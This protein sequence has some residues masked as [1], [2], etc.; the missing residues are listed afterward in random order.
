MTIANTQMKSF[1]RQLYQMSDGDT[2][3]A[4]SMYDIG[5][6]LGLEKSAAGTIAED[7]II[8]GYAELKTLSGGIT[9]TAEGLQALDIKVPSSAGADAHAANIVVLT[10]TEVLDAEAL[11]A[12]EKI[13]EE[14]KGA[15]GGTTADYGKIEELVI[16]IKTLETQLLSGRPKTA[17]AREVLRSLSASLKDGNGNTQLAEKISTMTGDH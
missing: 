11:Q 3:T 2:D 14:I 8:D 13:L 10:T 9:I 7:L 5:A 6:I 16:D 4:V 1:L 12:V 17:I 15:V